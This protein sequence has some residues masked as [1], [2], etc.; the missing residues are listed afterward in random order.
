MDKKHARLDRIPPPFPYL[1]H[2]QA[3]DPSF[4]TRLSSKEIRETFCEGL[5]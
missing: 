2:L 1:K 4:V 5:K 3:I